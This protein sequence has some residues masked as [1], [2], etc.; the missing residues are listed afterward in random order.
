MTKT[1]PGGHEGRK[2][3]YDRHWKDL[4]DMREHIYST[5]GNLEG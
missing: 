3:T 4:P 1:R 5:A 2:E